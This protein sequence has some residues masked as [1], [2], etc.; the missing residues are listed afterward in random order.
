MFGVVTN[1]AQW[2]LC[3]GGVEGVLHKSFLNLTTNYLYKPMV[4]DYL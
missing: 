1:A 4:F 2:L 3:Y